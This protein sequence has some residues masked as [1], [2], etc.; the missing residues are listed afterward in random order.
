M[1]PLTVATI[2]ARLLSRVRT[3]LVVSDHA[4]LS[5]H[6]PSRATQAALK[7]SARLFYPL[8]DARVAVSHGAA[9]DLANLSGLP[10][11]RFTVIYNPVEFPTDVQ[12]TD[13]VES[14]WGGDGAR[15]LTVGKLKEEK[16]QALLLRAFA[17]LPRELE[18]RLMIVG[19]GP[20]LDQLQALA[21]DLGIEARVL[22]PGYV[23]NPWP[24]YASASLF[25]LPSREESFGNVLV[26]ALHARLPIISTRTIG[27]AEVL[28]G[29]RFGTLVDADAAALAAAIEKGL[30]RPSIGQAGFERARQLSGETAL[31]TYHDLLVGGSGW[32]H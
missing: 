17:R 3:R 9:K 12:P 10:A 29:G 5:D 7:Y 30:A 31:L 11:E 4:I 23:A 32:S 18:A 22:F 25:V 1:W 6:Y 8:A 16:N 28:D 27:A 26:E 14:A 15:I 2:I 19:D 24:F 20:L 21:R 13:E